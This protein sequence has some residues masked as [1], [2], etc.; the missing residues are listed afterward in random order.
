MK[1][2]LLFLI[3]LFYLSGHAQFST[4]TCD[5]NAIKAALSAN[6]DRLFVQGFPCAM[7]FIAKTDKSWLASQQDAMAVGANLTSIL[8][9]AENDAIVQAANAQ[10]ITGGA[11]IGYTDAASEG[12]W[13]WVDGSQSTFTNWNGGE[14]NNSGGLPCY[15]D[16]DAALIQFSNGKWNDLAV[17]NICGGSLGRGL[18]KVNLCPVVNAP[19]SV[20]VCAG[21]NPTITA[22]GSFGSKKS[23]P[24]S[25]D[26]AWFIPPSTNP[27]DLD[28]VYNQ[29]T[30]SST[31][32]VVAIRDRYQCS[33]TAIVNIVVNNC[34]PPSGPKGCNIPQIINTFTSQGYI[35]L[36]VQGQDCSL[37]F[38]NPT[39][40]D[41]AAAQAA[42]Q[43]LGANL[44]VMNDAQENQ[45][46][47][48]ALNAQNAFALASKI[49]IGYKRTGVAAPTFYPLDSS[50]GPFLTPTTGGPTP[51]IF[52][53]WAPN[54]PNN[55]GYQCSPV[56][57]IGCNGYACVNGEQCV[58]IYSNGLWNDEKCNDGS[59]IS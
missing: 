29:P 35:Q 6:Y 12:N 55:Q 48:N 52:Q 36:N 32:V 42:A 3:T 20:T 47:V 9:Q 44:V 21:V 38:I 54:E 4:F 49:W 34:T 31:P 45:N 51:G 19:P 59:S 53:N 13:V 41:A 28:S 26:Y 10:G 17:Q 14:P 11:W 5:T 57:G 27:V 56:C 25:Y 24:P 23:S 33:D 46:V 37:Y 30:P 40:Q 39:S 1:K 8:S 7:Y 2:I 22:V 16:E 15:Q 50:T 18:I 58:Q 43:A